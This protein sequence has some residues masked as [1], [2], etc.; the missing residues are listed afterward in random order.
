MGRPS[1]DKVI[2]S[3]SVD[4]ITAEYI[5]KLADGD[6]SRFVS[7]VLKLAVKKELMQT[8]PQVTERS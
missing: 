1:Q 3:Y 6:R 7:N 5:D 8:A 4:R 2:R